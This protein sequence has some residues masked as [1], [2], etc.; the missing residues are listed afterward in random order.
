M[1]SHSTHRSYTGFLLSL[2]LLASSVQGHGS[3]S[4][5]P[6]QEEFGKTAD[7]SFSGVTT[8]AHLPHVKCLDEPETPYDIALLGIPFDSAVSYRPGM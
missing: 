5:D 8:F 4:H 6:W 3:P 1:S 7:L 2:F